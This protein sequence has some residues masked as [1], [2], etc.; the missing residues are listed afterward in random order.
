MKG[1]WK[2]WPMESREG[3]KQPNPYARPILGKCYRC[4]QPGHRSNECPNRRAVNMVEQKEVEDILCD[5]NEGEGYDE[6]GDGEVEPTYVIRR[7]ML[8]S[9]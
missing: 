8:T 4:N 5:P 6:E 1:L 7:M 9:K 3:Q 2:K